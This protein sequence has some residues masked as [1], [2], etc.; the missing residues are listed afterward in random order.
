MTNELEIAYETLEKTGIDQKYSHQHSDIFKDVRDK[1]FKDRRDEEAKL[2]Q[3]EIDFLNFNIHANKLS[4]LFSGTNEKG[5]PFEYPSLKQFTEDTYNHLLKRQKEVKNPFLKAKYSHL[6]WLSPKKKIEYAKTAIDS[7]IKL[8]PIRAKQDKLYPTNH[9]G[10]QVLE[11]ATNAFLLSISTKHQTEKLKKIIIRLVLKYS[12]TSSSSGVIRF[13]LIKLMLSNKKLFD[14]KDFKGVVQV[15]KKLYDKTISEKNTH[16]AI[17]VIELI[18]KVEQR[19][20]N[21]TEYW[22]RRIAELWEELSYDREDGTNLVSTEFCKTAIK[23]FK[24]LKDTKKVKE[25]EK[26]FDHLRKNLTLTQIGQ[27]F[28]LTEAIM[29]FRKFANDL[30]NK[31]PFEII[32]RLVSDNSLLPTYDKVEKQAKT[33]T[34]LHPFM[35]MA[36]TSIIDKYGN[37]SQYFSDADEQ[38]YYALLR[39]YQLSLEISH[40][41]LI[42]EVIFAC[43]KKGKLTASNILAFLKQYSWL[44]KELHVKTR[45]DREEAY[46][47]LSLIAPGLNEYFINLEF[48]FRNPSNVPNLVLCI[49][50]LTLKIEGMLRDICEFNGVTTYELKHDKKGRT[51]SQEKDIHKLLYEEEIKRLIDKDDILFL[52]FLLVEKAGYNLRHKVAHSLMTFREYNINYMNLLVLA[53]L[54]FGKYDFTPK[55]EA[56]SK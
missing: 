53:I 46:S 43:V 38:E 39:S 22:Q 7:Y 52:K 30:S 45:G 17:D 11:S 15:C 14:V 42:R 13:R 50:S 28:D 37:H 40:N 34:E 1:L 31:E 21:P 24:K 56:K 12:T 9:F 54:K 55:E 2:A 4:S 19:L 18:I 20:G 27:E 35:F 25:L 44:G 51:I 29:A 8:I 26:R 49:D 48:F 5:E 16:S 33:S 47:W 3:Y 6:L 32:G 10:L 23:L 36:S 41:H